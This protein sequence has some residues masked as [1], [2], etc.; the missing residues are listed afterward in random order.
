MYSLKGNHAKSAYSGTANGGSLRVKHVARLD[1]GDVR[2][3]NEE[4]AEFDVGV[5]KGVYDLNK[6]HFGQTK[7]TEVSCRVC[8]GTKY[9]VNRGQLGESFISICPHCKGTR[10]M[11]S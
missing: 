11:R 4:L 9:V 1:D 6:M 3:P 7:N 10:R 2:Q 8:M 5:R